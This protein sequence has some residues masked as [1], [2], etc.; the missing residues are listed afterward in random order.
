M[1]FFCISLAISLRSIRKTVRPIWDTAAILLGW[2]LAISLRSIRKTVRPIWDTAA[3]RG[4]LIS[5]RDYLYPHPPS[6]QPGLGWMRKNTRR[7]WRLLRVFRKKSCL[8]SRD[9]VFFAVTPY[10][11]EHKQSSSEQNVHGEIRYVFGS[12]FDLSTDVRMHLVQNRLGTMIM[13]WGRSL[14]HISS[15]FG[16]TSCLSHI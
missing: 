9:E 11:H 7:R 13:G 8:L 2:G 1:D 16:K 14:S 15:E 3:H 4:S 12:K 6:R 5:I 10:H